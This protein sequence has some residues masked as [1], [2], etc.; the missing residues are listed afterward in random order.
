M[1]AVDFEWCMAA[2]ALA[3]RRCVPHSNPPPDLSIRLECSRCTMLALHYQHL[4]NPNVQVNHNGMPGGAAGVTYQ[5]LQATFEVL[6]TKPYSKGDQVFISYG[7]RSNDQLLQY[8][9][10]VEANNANDVY[11]FDN[12]ARRL[13]DACSKLSI[14]ALGLDEYASSNPAPT[15]LA[16]TGFDPTFMSDMDKMCGGEAQARKVLSSLLQEELG[17]YATSL[18]ADERA[19]EALSKSS[20]ARMALTLMLRVEKKRLLAENIA[21]LSR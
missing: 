1:L 2:S 15:L 9:G 18:E 6:S 7:E 19:F 10:F 14:T 17:K 13:A 21:M 12:I 16:P 4:K 11:E 5:A 3:P 8:Y 20:D